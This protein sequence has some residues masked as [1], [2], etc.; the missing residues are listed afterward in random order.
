M[1]TIGEK[2]CAI[3][4]GRLFLLKQ[5]RRTHRL[6]KEHTVFLHFMATP[7]KDP[8]DYKKT[9][10]P[11]KIATID[12]NRI[13][14]LVML[15]ATEEEVADFFG[16]CPA[17]VANYKN[18]HPEFLEALKEGKAMSDAQVE[19]SLFQRATG[20]SHPEEKI[21]CSEGEIIKEDTVKHYPPDTTA[22]IFWLKNR[23]PKEW[24]EKLDLGGA[25]GGSLK[26]TLTK[27][28]EN[29]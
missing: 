17:T 22:C 29:I 10:R 15:G 24:R 18:E 26:I 6:N 9:G 7:R 2:S 5:K 27:E 20:Y 14:K 4:T 16:I 25:D 23:K 19:K 1:R 8:K 12:L 13:K 3:L 28:D 21:F 11:S